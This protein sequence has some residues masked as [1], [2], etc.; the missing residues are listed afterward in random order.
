[1]FESIIDDE[2]SSLDQNLKKWIL[3]SKKN[4]KKQKKRNYF[5]KYAHLQHF[6]ITRAALAKDFKLFQ[7]IKS[8]SA[9]N[10]K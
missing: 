10:F 6:K 4:N 1:M 8:R 2:K 9:P 3:E 7:Q 5:K